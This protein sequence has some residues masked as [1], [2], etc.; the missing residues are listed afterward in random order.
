MKAQTGIK[1]TDPRYLRVGPRERYWPVSRPGRFTARKDPRYPM[2][3]MLG[4]RKPVWRFRSE[5]G[6]CSSQSMMSMDLIVVPVEVRSVWYSNHIS[7]HCI[8]GAENDRCV[9]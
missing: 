9:M 7:S 6:L 8:V 2:N 1:R 5:D 4:G 3:R